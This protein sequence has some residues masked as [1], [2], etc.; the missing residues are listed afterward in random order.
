MNMDMNDLLKILAAPFIG[1][2]IQ[3]ITNARSK[4]R[5]KTDLELLELYK[6]VDSDSTS[7][8]AFKA[9]VDRRL[10]NTYGI[11]NPRRN[12]LDVSGSCLEFCFS[13]YSYKSLFKNGLIS[14]KKQNQPILW[15]NPTAPAARQRCTPLT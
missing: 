9:E 4:A 7:Y 5:L 14:L 6:K 15:V 10:K 2:V 13:N 11:E 3:W 8:I 1:L 12:D